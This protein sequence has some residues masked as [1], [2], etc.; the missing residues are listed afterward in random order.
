[1][2]AESVEVCAMDENEVDELLVWGVVRNGQVALDKPLDL[3]DGALVWVIDY[4]AASDPDAPAPLPP[5]PEKRRE[6]MIGLTGRLDLADDP[7]W[8]TKIL[9][10]RE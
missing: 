7:D 8:E 10:P 5:S 3:P 1:M 9:K 6:M 2:V 4:D